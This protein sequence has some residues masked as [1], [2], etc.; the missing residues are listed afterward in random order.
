M[1]GAPSEP[2]LAWGKLDRQAPDPKPRLSL[3]A[4]CIDVAAVLAAL[5]ELP[6]W[7]RRLQRL[8]GRTLDEIDLQ[9]LQVLAFLHDVGKAGAGFYSKALPPAEQLPLSQQS[10]TRAVAPLLVNDDPLYESLRQAIGFW[11]FLRWSDNPGEALSLW[12]AAVSHH[13][14]PITLDELGGLQSAYKATWSTQL[15]DYRPLQGLQE[16]GR[17]ARHLWPAAWSEE[18]QSYPAPLQHAFA[19]LVSLADWIG[20]NTAAGFF[21]YALGSQDAGRWPVARGRAA[22]A[23]RAMGLD[24]RAAQARAAPRERG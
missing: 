6:S 3:V 10:H 20:S 19:G 21:P 8:A 9:R 22:E 16:L 11:D 2:G 5:L 23:L 18:P 17:V 13:G 12:L 4:H 7:R 14:Q 15:G 24:V 1:S